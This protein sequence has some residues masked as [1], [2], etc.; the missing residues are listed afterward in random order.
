VPNYIKTVALVNAENL[1]D[2]G[3]GDRLS[4]RLRFN[5]LMGK[6][7]KRKSY[8]SESNSGVQPAVIRDDNSA[9]HCSD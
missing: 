9:I 5:S 1:E 2:F 3:R 8:I 7:I 4:S 6:T